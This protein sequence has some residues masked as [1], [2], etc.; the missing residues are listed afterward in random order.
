MKINKQE[1]FP[2][3]VKDEVVRLLGQPYDKSILSRKYNKLR[4]WR[5]MSSNGHYELHFYDDKLLRITHFNSEHILLEFEDE[6]GHF[7]NKNI[8]KE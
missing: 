5:Y 1:I 2:L 7:V 4:T 8:S 6:S 3:M